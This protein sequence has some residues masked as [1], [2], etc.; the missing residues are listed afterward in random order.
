MNVS[1][2]SKVTRTVSE[3]DANALLE[4][5]QIYISNS[6]G[7]LHKWVGIQNVP[8]DG[9]YLRYG[10]YLAEAFAGDSVT[11]SFDKKYFKGQQDFSVGAQVESTQVNIVCK[12][13]NVVTSIDKGTIDYDQVENLSVVFENSRGDLTFQGDDLFKKGYFMMPEGDS[14]IKYTISGTN[15]LKGNTFTKVG[16]IENVK[17]GYEY[18]LEFNWTSSG[19]EDGGAMFS[20]IIVE[21]KPEEDEVIIYGAPA[22]SWVGNTPSIEEQLIGTPGTFESKVLRIAAYK[23]FEALVMTTEDA[24]LIRLLGGRE[25]EI[26]DMTEQ[27]MAKMEE[28]GIRITTSE[29][30]NELYKYFI[31]FSADFLNSLPSSSTE[32]VLTIEAI[33]MQQ[34]PKDCVMQVRIANTEEAIIYTSPVRLE[35]SSWDS[36]SNPM[37][38]L[39][40]SATLPVVFTKDDVENPALQYRESGTSNWSVVP[41]TV[42]RALSGVAELKNLKS[43]TTYECRAVAGEVTNGE[44]QFSSDI[45]SF[46]TESEFIVPNSSME[47]WSKYGSQ[48]IIFPG[49]GDTRTF[50][51]SGNEGANKAGEILT[52]QSTDMAHIGT[53]SARLESKFASI[54]GVGKFA[55]GNLFVGRY[56]KTDGTDGVLEFGRPYNGSHP[57]AL[58]LWANY[59]PERANKKGANNNYLKEGDLDQAQIY[60]AIST[61]PVEIRT[62]SA[63]KLFNI[64]D[65]EI[66]AYGQVTWTENFGPDGQLQEVTIPIEYN[67]RAKTNKPTHLIIVCSASKFGD[68]FCGGEGST[69]YVDDFELVYE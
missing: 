7:V 34:V 69:M 41:V 40:K 19:S 8:K 55:A 66:L 50:W 22:F 35:P 68:Y 49:T 38:V 16:E 36:E 9:V 15:I 17:P 4:N 48:K 37:A 28:K 62:K 63:A 2:N 31:E 60:V 3:D 33:D 14:T 25:F 56:V 54:F 52:D 51:D 12:I 42:P 64:N 5:C 61:A 18:R 23:G 47:D 44:Y 29:P 24:E 11:A 43:A 39:A 30:S 45:T 21:E 58:K 1:V 59:R 27:G 65:P 20:I 6:K 57:T 46:T 10:T 67:E 26:D 32:Y 53:K 13:A